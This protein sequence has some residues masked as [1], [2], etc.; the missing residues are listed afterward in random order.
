MIK[1]H[2][3]SFRGFHTVMMDVLVAHKT[4]AYELISSDLIWLQVVFCFCQ[5]EKALF[6]ST[7]YLSIYWLIFRSMRKWLNEFVVSSLLHSN[8]YGTIPTVSFF[9]L[10]G[11]TTFVFWQL[12]S[13]FVRD[14]WW[15]QFL[16]FY[17]HQ[18]KTSCGKAAS[19]SPQ[20]AE[21]CVCACVWLCVFAQRRVKGGN[22]GV[23]FLQDSLC[24]AS[25]FTIWWPITTNY[26]HSLPDI[27]KQNTPSPIH[28]LKQ[29]HL[30]HPQQ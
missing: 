14:E 30:I 9:F 10:S 13:Q 26:E 7:F 15:V 4:K 17:R 22:T 16:C 6:N 8:L 29:T 23:K 25:H 5:H 19:S 3:K 11:F 2:V 21:M 1:V 20:E 27:R 28:T 24:A 18:H 12:F